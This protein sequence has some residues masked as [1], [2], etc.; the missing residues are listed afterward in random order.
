MAG[1][2]W[3][4]PERAESAKAVLACEVDNR[5]TP[6]QPVTAIRRHEQAGTRTA[7]EY[8]SRSTGHGRPEVR[9]HV[10][11]ELALLAGLEGQDELHLVGIHFLVCRVGLHG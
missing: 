6:A 9:S 7:R 4:R 2:I 3:G 10:V 1:R 11:A 8:F 5:T